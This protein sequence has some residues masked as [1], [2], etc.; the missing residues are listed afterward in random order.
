MIGWY[1]RGYRRG[2]WRLILIRLRS[3]PTSKGMCRVRYTAGFCSVPVLV[4]GLERRASDCRTSHRSIKRRKRFFKRQP[5]GSYLFV[6]SRANR[7]D[8]GDIHRTFYILSRQIGLRGSADSRGP[9]L[10]DMRH[11][12]A[13]NTLLQ[14]YRAGEDVERR[15]PK[16]LKMRA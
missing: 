14:W 9:R 16:V 10:H 5:I 15:L 2:L 6:S 3:G 4:N 11:R 1:V 12:F 7:L 13:V 8:I